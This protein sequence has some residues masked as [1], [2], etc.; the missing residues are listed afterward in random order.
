MKHKINEK[1]KTRRSIGRRLWN[2][3]AK[4]PLFLRGP[5]IR[6]LFFI[7][8]EIPKNL[9]FKR[10]D[11]TDEIEQAFKVAYEAY[12]ERGLEQD[13]ENRMRVTKHHA[14]PTTCI[15]I[16]KLD[17][18]VVATMTII[19]DSA[20][21]LPIEKLWNIDEVRSSSTRIA[22]ISTL[23]IKRGFRA[24]RGKLLLPL[25]GFMY[26][27]CTRY[28]GVEKIVATFHPEVQD[29]YRCVLL[30]NDIGGGEVKTYEFVKG[31][32]AVGGWLSL[33]ELVVNYP[34]VYGHKNHKRNL[35]HYFTT[36]KIDNYIF[37]EQKH[38][39]CSRF[40]FTPALLDYFFRNRSETLNYLT[41]EEKFVIANAYF[42]P[43]YL[44]VILKD[45]LGSTSIDRKQIRIAVNYEVNWSV[46]GI[47]S[48][49]SGRVLE[50]SQKG[51]RISKPLGLEIK[52]GTQSTLHITLPSGNKI[53]I[54]GEV[55]WV[56]RGQV[57]LALG[58]FIPSEWTSLLNEIEKD[59]VNSIFQNTD[60]HQDIK[61][62]S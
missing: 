4:L 40:T 52:A 36:K 22:E 14:L 54:V 2:L 44:S 47:E 18:E 62:S 31:A 6:R 53:P 61:K 48:S 58:Q 12:Y 57:G 55:K 16:A 24:Q 35:F 56:Q 11:T 25:C 41:S 50:I 38:L 1:V 20:L 39:Y 17:E 27:Y 9:V 51:L 21:G 46:E 19:V 7:D 3:F 13:T 59:V 5:I 45:G 8:Y 15:L 37:E 32:A 60:E 26:R 23:A 49:Q 33:S 42:Y 29:F 28:L 30:F 10:A 34:K 43:E